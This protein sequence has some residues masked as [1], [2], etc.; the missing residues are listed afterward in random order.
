MNLFLFCTRDRKLLKFVNS[1]FLTK[2]VLIHVHIKFENLIHLHGQCTMY[3]FF[4]SLL[5]H[6]KFGL[7]I[8]DFLSN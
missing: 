4:R 3:I 7:M 5:L 6:I 1:V 2:N 8:K